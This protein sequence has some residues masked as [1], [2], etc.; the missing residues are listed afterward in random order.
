MGMYWYV[1]VYM[2][3]Y[4]FI[5][6]YMGI[7]GYVWLYIGIYGY[8]WLYMCIYMGIYGYVWL[9]V[10]VGWILGS[11]LQLVVIF[12]KCRSYFSHGGKK[13]LRVSR[14]IGI[15]SRVI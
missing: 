5:W 4:V 3:I 9:V 2:G 12:I 10:R 13:I 8:V 7:Y 11:M 6:V 15:N 1:W 14:R